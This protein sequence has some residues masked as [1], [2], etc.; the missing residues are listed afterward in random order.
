MLR[1]DWE[2]LEEFERWCAEQID[3]APFRPPQPRPTPTEKEPM[4]VLGAIT[5][6][7]IIAAGLFGIVNLTLKA[8]QSK[9]QAA[10]EQQSELPVQWPPAGFR[11]QFFGSQ[12][13][14]PQSDLHANWVNGYSETIIPPAFIYVRPG[15]PRDGEVVHP[16][17]G[18]VY[19][20]EQTPWH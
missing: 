2:K 19:Y 6:V 3:R 8:P 9:P 17:H 16:S 20:K 18:N 10:P 12:P 15:H 7:C 11:M 1:K 5:A 13:S 14:T 4:V